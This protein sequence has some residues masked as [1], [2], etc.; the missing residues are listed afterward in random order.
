MKNTSGQS[1]NAKWRNPFGNIV[2]IKV[3]YKN[4]FIPGFYICENVVTGETLNIHE[5]SILP[6]GPETTANELHSELKTTIQDSG[7]LCS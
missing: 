7:D 6:Y 5:N 4:D 1:L 2:D 3:H